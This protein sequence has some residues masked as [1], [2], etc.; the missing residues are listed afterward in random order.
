MPLN[1]HIYKLTVSRVLATNVSQI[2]LGKL[3]FR[4]TLKVRLGSCLSLLLKWTPWTAPNQ[5][6]FQ[7]ITACHHSCVQE[8][9]TNDKLRILVKAQPKTQSI[10]PQ[11]PTR[12]G[13]HLACETW[14]YPMN[15]V[16]V[17][18][19]FLLLLDTSLLSKATHSYMTLQH[20]IKLRVCKKC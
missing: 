18:V 7:K 10:W 9:S 15:S 17:I 19:A 1:G 11:S 14:T 20:S 16:L 8:C 2:N 3:L 12:L 5:C 4:A 6:T 13:I